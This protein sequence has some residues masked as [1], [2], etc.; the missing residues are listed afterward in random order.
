MNA[1]NGTDTKKTL[2]SADELKA[3]IQAKPKMILKEATGMYDTVSL[4]ALVTEP[5]PLTWTDISTKDRE[6]KM[7]LPKQDQDTGLIVY[8]VPLIFAQRLVAGEPYKY[9]L[10]DPDRIRAL[11][12]SK[13][14]GKE[15]RTFRS[16][17]IKRDD[18]KVCKDARG[19]PILVEYPDWK[20]EEKKEEE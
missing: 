18:G 17:Y 4:A 10:M 2:P 12:V 9:K 5:I 6:K 19:V 20:K 13:S 14:G 8:E 16:H 3:N 15:W 1:T 11:C 7:F